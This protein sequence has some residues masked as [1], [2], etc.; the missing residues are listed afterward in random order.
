MLPL[1]PDAIADLRTSESIYMAG[2]GRFNVAGLSDGNVDRFAEAVV[3][4]L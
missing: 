1:S 4:R 2:S 3:A